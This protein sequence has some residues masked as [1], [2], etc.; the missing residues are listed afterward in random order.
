MSIKCLLSLFLLIKQG[1]GC[2]EATVIPFRIANDLELIAYQKKPQ[3][4]CSFM[5]SLTVEKGLTDVQLE[6]RNVTQRFHSVAGMFW[7]HLFFV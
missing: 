5:R 4:I 3:A 1:D 6:D 7:L 2:G